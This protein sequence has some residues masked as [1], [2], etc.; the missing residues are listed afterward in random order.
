VIAVKLNTIPR[1]TEN[2]A[3]GAVRPRQLPP[4]ASLLWEY[5]GT[6]ARRDRE[7]SV[8]LAGLIARAAKA[9]QP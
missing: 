9:V 6:E 3:I 7:G 5:T 1:P 8:L 2:A 4:L